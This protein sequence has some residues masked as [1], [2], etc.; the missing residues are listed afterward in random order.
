MAAVKAEES[1]IGS[2]SQTAAAG[3][4]AASSQRPSAAVLRSAAGGAGA[5]IEQPQPDRENSA[6]GAGSACAA[7]IAS[8]CGPQQQGPAAPIGSH[9]SARAS[10]APWRAGAGA[11]RSPHATAGAGIPPMVNTIART[12]LTIH[13]SL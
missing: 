1:L 3:R 13:R 9:D 6:P 11:L 12:R 2:W 10:G 5:W 4:A 7:V 8:D